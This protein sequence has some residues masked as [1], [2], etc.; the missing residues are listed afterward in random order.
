MGSIGILWNPRGHEL[1]SLCTPDVSVSQTQFPGI[2]FQSEE[3][4][5]YLRH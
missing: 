5:V 3:T 1:E 4:T 2:Q